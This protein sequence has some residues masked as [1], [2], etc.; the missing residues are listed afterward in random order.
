MQSVQEDL[1][2]TETKTIISSIN[3]TKKLNRILNDVQYAIENDDVIKELKK[4]LDEKIPDQSAFSL[5][6]DKKLFFSEKEN[7]QK[8]LTQYV[9]MKIERKKNKN[10]VLINTSIEHIYPENPQEK[11]EK[12]SKPE[13][14]KNIGNL[15]LLDGEL[16]SSIGN[17]PFSQKKSTILNKSHIISTKEVFTGNDKWGV[18]EIIARNEALRNILYIDIWKV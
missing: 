5:Y 12:L 1:L 10:A 18:D 14:I 4:T 3:N 8:A 17:T 13:L 16:N 2:D 11:W 15:V 7:K 6:F 9:L